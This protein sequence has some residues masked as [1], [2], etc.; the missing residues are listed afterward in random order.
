MT[1]DASATKLATVSSSLTTPIIVERECCFP[2][3][4]SHKVRS[5]YNCNLNG[6]LVGGPDQGDDYND[7]QEDYVMNEVAIDYNAG[8][9]SALA[10][11]NH[12]KA[13]GSM[14]QTHNKCAC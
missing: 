13:A 10:V 14:P 11:I 5:F 8:F 2:H 7:R 12:L 9:Q 1:E 4:W 3:V 6:A